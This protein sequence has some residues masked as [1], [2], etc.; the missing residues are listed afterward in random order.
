[1]TKTETIP[2][3]TKNLCIEEEDKEKEDFK[4]SIKQTILIRR[5]EEAKSGFEKMMVLE[6]L[7][8]NVDG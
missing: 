8:K 5:M 4:A 7:L 1:M 3:V 6:D 2:Q